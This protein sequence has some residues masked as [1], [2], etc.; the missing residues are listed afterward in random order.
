MT[1]LDHRLTLFFYFLGALGIY[2]ALAI[3]IY[4]LLILDREERDFLKQ[5]AKSFLFKG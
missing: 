5:R 1:H 3:P 4:Y 2:L